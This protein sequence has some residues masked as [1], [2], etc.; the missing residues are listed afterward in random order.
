MR[1][2]LMT[3]CVLLNTVFVSAKIDHISVH[4]A[5]MNKDIE[6]T[7]VLP[8]GYD[9]ETPCPVLYLLHGYGGNQDKW[10][11]I[12]PDLPELATRYNMIVVCPDGGTSWYWDSP[13]DS[14]LRYETFVSSELVE[15]IDKRYKTVTDKSGRAITGYSM[16]GH[17]AL[18]LGFRHQDTFG[19]CGATSG[20][21]DIRPFPENWD[22]KKSLGD[23]SSHLDNWEN[24]TIASQ[25]HLV[26]PDYP[27]IIDCGTEDFFYDVNQALHD[28]M[29]YRNIKHE[30]IT[31]PG[32]HLEPY[33]AISIEP[34][35]LFFSNFFSGKPV[36]QYKTKRHEQT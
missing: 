12:K 26:R 9:G 27:V 5:A 1:Y 18:W 4:S 32:I 13:V 11:A 33:W 2:F 36:Y 30:Y 20:G 23:Y 24:H 14:T 22:I 21:V 34:Q 8:E 31:R 15:D 10:L 6:S 28:E 25:L 7:V 16:G 29:L 35:M 19:A 3:L 17:G